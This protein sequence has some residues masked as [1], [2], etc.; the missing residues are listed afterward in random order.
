MDGKYIGHEIEYNCTGMYMDSF[1]FGNPEKVEETGP[2]TLPGACHQ[3]IE[4]FPKVT[5][6]TAQRKDKVLR[7]TKECLN[8]VVPSIDPTWRLLC[9]SFGK[10]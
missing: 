2:W 7:F 4:S 6:H 5:Q 9:P 8:S 3:H 10:P 1:D